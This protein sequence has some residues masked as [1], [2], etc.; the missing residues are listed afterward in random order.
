[1]ARCKVIAH[2]DESFIVSDVRDRWPHQWAWGGRWRD[3]EAKKMWLINK[4]PLIPRSRTPLSFFSSF[5][6]LKAAMKRND[7]DDAS[8]NR[9]LW[10]GSEA[11]AGN[12]NEIPS[13]RMEGWRDGG[14]SHAMIIE[15]SR[16]RRR[17]LS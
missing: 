9:A 7:D 2:G 10:K 14:F 16:R 8:I 6:N 1:M 4:T 15:A 17:P 11:A 5:D 13:G 12:E 3:K